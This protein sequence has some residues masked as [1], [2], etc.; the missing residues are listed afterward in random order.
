ML[1]WVFATVI[2]V[3]MLTLAKLSLSGEQPKSP[4]AS[5]VLDALHDA[6][7]KAD[8]QRY[9]ALFAP[10]ALFLGTD[11][12]ERWTLDEFKTFAKPYFVQGKGWT[13][14]PR[15]DARHFSFSP[16]GSI[17]WFDELLDNAKYGECR[18]TGVLRRVDGHGE[19]SGWKI[20]QYCLTIPIPNEL[21]GDIVGMI[22]AKAAVASQPIHP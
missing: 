2:A 22:K 12:K 5:A 17:A 8:G 6:A 20:E 16:D 4:Q 7:S 14:V 11:A 18:G 3:T 15:K 21:A 10:D 13:Y 9:F 1:K 19:A